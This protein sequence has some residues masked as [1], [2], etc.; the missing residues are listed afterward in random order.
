MTLFG[1][2]KASAGEIRVDGRPRRIRKP[3][4]AIRHRLGIALVP[5]DRKTEGLMLSMSVR[6]NLTLAVLGPISHYGVVNPATERSY[7]RRAVQ[8]RTDEAG[9]AELVVP[10]HTNRNIQ[11]AASRTIQ[12]VDEGPH[13]VIDRS[14]RESTRAFEFH[15]N[16][17]P[18]R[19]TFPANRSLS[20]PAAVRN[21]AC[22]APPIT[23]IR[24]PPV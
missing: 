23:P 9:A 24:W 22:I 15:T 11:A 4:D 7:V 1:A 8:R 13:A 5:E 3:S 21:A 17:A 19:L 18:L 6:D 10:Q 14:A 16:R 20:R 12:K 2:S